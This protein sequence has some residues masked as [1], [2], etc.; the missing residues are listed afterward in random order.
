MDPMAAL[1]R[2]ETDANEGFQVMRL[3]NLVQAVVEYGAMRFP[4]V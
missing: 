1:L 4:P 3:T 2:V